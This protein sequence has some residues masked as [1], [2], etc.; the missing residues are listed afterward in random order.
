MIVPF[1]SNERLGFLDDRDD[2]KSGGCGG[3]WK[4]TEGKHNGGAWRKMEDDLPKRMRWRNPSYTTS[5][6]P[7]VAEQHWM[8][9]LTVG[10][11]VGVVVAGAVVARR[12]GGRRELNGIPSISLVSSSDERW[13]EER[14]V[15]L[16]RSR[17]NGVATSNGTL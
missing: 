17:T 10:E 5:P 4:G 12:S 6:A 1:A 16:M 13:M 9:V 8:V 11:V 15:T 2:F 14:R 3:A 7:S